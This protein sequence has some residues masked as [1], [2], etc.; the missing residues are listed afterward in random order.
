MFYT[1]VHRSD[2][3]FLV[4]PRGRYI[5]I[6]VIA[7]DI[8]CD[9]LVKVMPA[10]NMLFF[11]CNQQFLGGRCFDIMQ[12]LCFFLKL[13]PSKFSIHPQILPE[14]ITMSGCSN[15]DFFDSLFL[16]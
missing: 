5:S 8:N 9:N 16:P 10:V 15:G 3:S 6:C 7:G 1:S 14:T 2:M 11:L 12:I 4:H 13:L